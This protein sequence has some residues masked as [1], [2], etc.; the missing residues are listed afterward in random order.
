[1]LAEDRASAQLGRRKEKNRSEPLWETCT[2]VAQDAVSV[3]QRQPWSP[4]VGPPKIPLGVYSHAG[5]AR[6]SPGSYGMG[7]QVVPGE[8][9]RLRSVHY[10]PQM[11]FN[12]SREK[13]LRVCVRWSYA[14]RH[15]G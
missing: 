2:V 1:M 11:Q 4:K 8:S 10:P 14:H 7:R 13:S 9:K 6:L 12:A 5:S 3:C 15:T